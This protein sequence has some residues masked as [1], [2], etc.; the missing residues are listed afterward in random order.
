MSNPYGLSEDALA[1]LRE[2]DCLCVYCHKEMI[3]PF[4]TKRRSDSATIEHF[5]HEPPWNN[6]ETVAYACGSCNSSKG[7]MPLM[8][9]LQKS[10]CVERNIT[11]NTVAQPVRDYLATYTSNQADQK[12][13]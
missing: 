2:R 3:Y 8:E 12:R 11:L 1:K 13:R 9:W 4:D 6:I 5:N 10:Y 7:A